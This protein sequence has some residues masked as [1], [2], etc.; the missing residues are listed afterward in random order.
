MPMTF[1]PSVK[2]ANLL[3]FF[4]PL[5]FLTVVN[6]SPAIESRI[7]D[8]KGFVKV[9]GGSFSEVLAG[10]ENFFAYRANVEELAA[11]GARGQE[12]NVLART[13]AGRE[14]IKAFSKHV[15]PSL[16]SPT[17]ISSGIQTVARKCRDH[18]VIFI[19]VSRS[20]LRWGLTSPEASSEN[21]LKD[22]RKMIDD[23]PITLK[24]SFVAPTEPV[25]PSKP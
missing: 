23:S 24:P 4:F 13:Y 22:F 10:Q 2:K 20:N 14:F 16:E 12:V 15:P 11:E 18:T 5:A 7:C 8:E 21:L 3:A 17:L 6:A 1:K 19:W 9:K 25:A